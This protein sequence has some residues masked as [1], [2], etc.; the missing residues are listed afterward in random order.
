MTKTDKKEFKPSPR[1][2]YPGIEIV[3]AARS[4]SGQIFV[5]TQK[6]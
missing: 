6:S 5:E 2:V 4:G 3:Q 1:R